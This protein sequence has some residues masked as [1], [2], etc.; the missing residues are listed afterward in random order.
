[1]DGY[2]MTTLALGHATNSLALLAT[3]TEGVSSYQVST[4]RGTQSGVGV[5]ISGAGAW[6]ELKG[7]MAFEIY[8]IDSSK[9]FSEMKSSYDIGG[10]VH[11]FWAWL[12]FGANA[13][14]HKSEVESMFKEI[15]NTQKVNGKASFDLMV[16]GLYPNVQVFA[17]AYVMV[18][19]VI[20]NL[21]NTFNM[22]SDG[23]PT[24]DTGAQDPNTG[25]TLP[26]SKNNSSISI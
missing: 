1:M 3:E 16:T 21:G 17:Q 10:G 8:S 24:S 2:V 15:T 7:E 23:D 11:G 5:T 6:A 9:T 13:E 26:S 22:I 4:K 18:L 25:S 19:Q 12:G 14:T 20:D